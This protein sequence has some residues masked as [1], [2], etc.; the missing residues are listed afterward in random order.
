MKKIVITFNV[1]WWII[2][3]I[4][5]GSIIWFVLGNTSNFQR[6]ID[7]EKTVILMVFGIPSLIL[8]TWSLY[9]LKNGG[10]KSPYSILGVVFLLVIMIILSVPLYKNVNTSGWL[11]ENIKVDTVQVTADNEYEYYTE[12]V[13]TFQRNSSIRLYLKNLTSNEEVRIKLDLPRVSGISWSS[14]ENFFTTLQPTQHEGKY[15]L[16]TQK[17]SPFPEATFEVD[18]KEAKAIRLE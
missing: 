9:M 11:T 17:L 18:V 3:A 4:N 2:V 6:D 13:N 10:V 15:I 8:L 14:K 1:I 7:L 16:R 12:L 5:L